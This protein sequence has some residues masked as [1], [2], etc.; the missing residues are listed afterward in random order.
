MP[1]GKQKV[2]H[3]TCEQYVARRLSEGWRPTV[4]FSELVRLMVEYD[5]EVGQKHLV[6][7]FS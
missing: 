7:P 2:L 3:E 4:T 6:A 1:I 5:L